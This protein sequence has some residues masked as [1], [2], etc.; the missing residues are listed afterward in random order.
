MIYGPVIPQKMFYGHLFQVQCLV[1][2]LW[3][4]FYGTRKN[5]VLRVFDYH[6]RASACFFQRRNYMSHVEYLLIVITSLDH[7]L[8]ADFYS[9]FMTMINNRSIDG[10]FWMSF[11]TSASIKFLWR[12]IFDFYCNFL[13]FLFFLGDFDVTFDDVMDIQENIKVILETGC[14]IRWKL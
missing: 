9:P 1:S 11:H 13:N 6:L 3:L 5:K 2:V 10:V 12:V 7:H 8:K 4:N 14:W